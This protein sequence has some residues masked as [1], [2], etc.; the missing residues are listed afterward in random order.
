[1]VVDPGRQAAQQ[2]ALLHA[3]AAQLFADM[4]ELPGLL[5]R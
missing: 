3:G 4:R 1:V 2:A 5:A